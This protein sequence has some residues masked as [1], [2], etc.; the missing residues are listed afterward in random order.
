MR[1]SPNA[2]A[3]KSGLL[4]AAAALLAPTA[5]TAH[6]DLPAWMQQ[7]VSAS[8]IESALYRMMDLPGL[9]TLYPRPPAE[10]RA[11][12][13]TLVQ[14][15]PTNPELY[16]LRARADEQALD[17]TAA[18]QDWKSYVAHAKD[19]PA[20]QLELADYY[21]RRLQPQQEIVTLTALAAA[22]SAPGETFVSASRQRS[23][24]AYS[25]ILKI[26]ADQA[27]PPEASTAAYTAWIARYPGEPS[28][29][30]AYV[31]T[32]IHQQ[33]FD[34]AT[35]VIND[36]KRA[37]PEDQVFPLKAAALIAYRS[38]SSE[39]ALALYAASFQ[40]LWPAELIQSYYGMAAAQH[41]P[42]ELLA[43]ARGAL[44][45]DPDDLAAATRI[46]FYFQQQGNLDAAARAFDEY[47]LSKAS[48]NTAWTCD[49]LY[50][51]ATLLK[52]V[53]LYA[54]SARYDFAL[55]NTPGKLTRSTQAPREAALSGIANIL[56]TAPEQSIDLG[57][58][59][60]SVY[61]DIATLDNGPGYLNG[62][63]SLWLNS[64]SPA[65]E[66]QQEEQ[67]AA[68]YFRRSKAAEVLALLDKDFPNAAT[69]PALHAALVRAYATYGDDPATI[70]A[71]EEFLSAFPNAP[72]RIPVA[73]IVADAYARGKNTT[74]EFAL[75]DHLLADLAH[76]AKGMPLTASTAMPPNPTRTRPDE[77]GDD[78]PASPVLKPTLDQ[79][80]DLTITPATI[81]TPPVD[82]NYSQLLERYLGRLTTTGKLP[83]ALAVLRRE[84]DRNP[85]DPLL[86]VRLADFLQQNNFAAQQEE[87]YRRAIARFNDTTFYD[88]LARF[89]LRK[90]RQQDFTT[91]TRQVVDTFRGTDLE[92]YFSNVNRSWPQV[93]LQLNLYAH[94]RFPHELKF[95]R[96]LLVAY[97]TKGTAD[98]AAWEL[99]LRQHW[100]EADDL[101]NQFFDYLSRTNKLDTELASLQQLVPAESQQQQNPA[102]TRELAEGN[103]WQ[104]H[105]EQSAPLLGSLAHDYPADTAIGDE[106]ASVYRS[107]AYFDPAQAAHAIII[108]QNLSTADPANLDRLTRIGD[109]LAN[110][111]STALSVSVQ[112][113]LAAAA[114][115][116]RR[117]PQ[118][119]PGQPDGY[120][121]A[122]TVFWDYFQF[123]A[124]LSQIDAARKQFHAP[125]LYAYEAG[126]ID[127]NKSAPVQAVAEY[128]TA[129]ITENPTGPARARLLTLAIRPAYAQLVDEATAKAV[130]AHP[131]L[132]TLTLRADVLAA[133]KQPSLV[134]PL[135]DL[136][137]THSST[138][139]QAANLATFA[140]L[141]QL[142]PSYRVA[143]E[144]EITLSADPVQR[145]ELQYTLARSYEQDSQHKDLAA[146]QNII[147]SVYKDDPK[148]LGVVRTT[149]D[150]YWTN[151][152]PQQAIAILVEA[153][154]S[155]NPELA[156]AF[157]LE[158]ATKSNQSSEYAQARTLLAP[159]LA[160]DPY[161]ARYLA[162]I[163]DSYALASD[164]TALR[165]FYTTTL[166]TLKTANLSAGDRRDKTASL[167]QGLIEALTRL[168]DYPGAVDQHIALIS[169]FPEDPG[170]AQ[171][172]ALYALRYNRQQQLVDFLNKT[173]ADSPRDSRFAIT[174]AHVDT[175]FEDYP[176]ALAAYNK[177]IAIR[178]DRPDVYIARADLEEH[179]QHFDEACADYD[180]L[181]VL[182]YKDP[183]WMLKAAEA[184]ARQGKTGLAVRALEAAWIDGR[185]I[186]PQNSFQVA[187]QL[188][189]WNLLT[190][191]RTF[192]EEGI[193]LASEKAPDDL[194]AVPEDREAAATYARILT[195]QRRPADALAVL[196]K[197]LAA[198]NVSPSSPGLIV[199][200]VEKQGIASVTDEQ[201]RR[202]RIEQRRTRAQQSY[203]N[204]VRAMSATVAEF[205]T[206]EEKL[207]Y[208]QLLDTQ[209]TGKSDAE[210][211]SVWIPAAEAAGL[212]DREAEWRRSLLLSRSHMAESQLSPFDTL[213]KQRMDYAVLARTLEDYAAS[214]PANHSAPILTMAADAWA[215]DA[216]HDAE[217]RILRTLNL[218]ADQDAALRE[219]YFRLL[220]AVDQRSLLAQA[221]SSNE[222]Y[223]DAAANYIFSHASQPLA[224]AALDARA[225]ARQP[226]W[227]A[228]NTALAGLF[229]GD[230]SPRTEAA[231]H[232]A[233]ADATIG[234]RL[235]H[236]ADR[237]RQLVGS[238]WFY[239]AT[240]YGVFRTLAPA[241]P[242]E[243]P[244]DYLPASLEA[245]PTAAASYINLAE[246][247]ANSGNPAAAVREYHY[248]LEITPRTAAI[249][250]AIAATLWPLDKPATD[251]PGALDQWQAA[252]RLLRALVNTRVV[253]ES[254]WIDFASIATDLHARDLGSQLRPE[255]DAL[256]RAYIA[257]NGNY[258]TAEL[259][260][261]ALNSQ[262]S[263]GTAATD[264]IFSLAD[265][266]RS[267]SSILDQLDEAN[268]FPRNQRG[269]LYRRQLELAE[270]AAAQ[271][272]YAPTDGSDIDNIELN[273]I[274]IKLLNYLLQQE[275]SASDS[276][277]QSLFN[278]IPASQRQQDDLQAIRIQLAARQNQVSRLLALFLAD[279]ANA[280]SLQII[281]NAANNLRRAGDKASNRLLLEYVFQ[282]KFEQHQ[283]TPPDFLALAQARLDA[284][285]AADTTSALDLLHRLIMLPGTATSGAPS[286]LYANLDA[287]ATLL[288]DAN[289]TAEAIPFLTTLATSTPWNADY[290]LRLAQAQRNVQP[291]SAEANGTLIDIAGASTTT[292][293]TRVE[294]AKFL[295]SKPGTKPFDSAE[296]NLLASGTSITPQQASQPYFLAARVA[297]AASAS[298]S[299]KPAL[300][301]E[302]IA[303]APGDSL[304]LD[305]FRAE[306][307]LRH[308][309]RALSAIQPLLNSPGGY[310]QFRNPDSVPDLNQAVPTTQSDDLPVGLANLPILLRAPE[311][312]V[313]FSLAVASVYEQTGYPAT[314]LNYL[315]TAATLNQ[316]LSCR[317]G[318]AKHIA[319]LEERL[320][321]EAENANRRPV[322]Q[323]GLN[324]AVVVRPRIASELVAAKQVQP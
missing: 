62:I 124:A 120:L 321:I 75:Y 196:Q 15:S 104:S 86:Y 268:W 52:N 322:I 304:R 55:Y 301:R 129:S 294:A 229:F 72:Q 267:P 30:T 74:A 26:A 227:G 302:A 200:Q 61:R 69:R 257:K 36:Y 309:D 96:N 274:R 29:R 102:A 197:T 194:L 183:Q 218:Q 271:R 262:A 255:M 27:L 142:I 115:Y 91:L 283:L 239:Y 123:D 201:W 113:Q 59:N 181:Y 250:R 310:S 221:S 175:I 19:I 158:A 125:A 83:Q 177:A 35:A 134:A 280:P 31:N 82:L 128:V 299:A 173:V 163:A 254:F 287:A 63:L 193:K 199:E 99:L 13:S 161:N 261:S 265:A 311:E 144:R 240:R 300:L 290:R 45:K 14:K 25:R 84:L 169:A 38:G 79:A 233:L 32:L 88:K 149:A 40:P 172:A 282:Q 78:T 278:S 157:T 155:A 98:S 180:H 11:E 216:N 108:E 293:A 168:K 242:S 228:A 77:M 3:R 179:L 198:A 174:L 307:D 241:S 220:L 22:P 10:S 81:P 2:I 270:A 320:R 162:T 6:A 68:P 212:K 238:D 223:A 204:A 298:A 184:R 65:S 43:D 225:H 5:L 105:F 87:V 316:D 319:D 211:A 111:Q 159:L 189:K 76:N 34:A 276:E 281:S 312:K 244:E 313:T 41:R 18:E 166:A 279:P 24:Q 190:E 317:S 252:L 314:A 215:D 205:Y 232:T 303:M 140:Q 230:K 214:R 70:K 202:N 93:Y 107:L 103:L 16:A 305:L 114:P 160:H 272:P 284:N 21:D 297:A 187:A 116:W 44:L 323:P 206:P 192:A 256:L 145:I 263:P 1:S 138:T 236:P 4:L 39:K 253:P 73:M 23:W 54:E 92:Q 153:S 90:K 291:G 318:I 97:R 226:V 203:E 243:D 80:L 100:F 141:H 112:A 57:S 51:L 231:F 224:Y 245:S 133:R 258:R 165:D 119:H 248:A 324:Q 295:K 109:T 127:E 143:L 89:Y 170:I 58:G 118:I 213:E 147:E 94:Q 71:G 286:D 209:R 130:P 67:R 217:L 110:S 277:A 17:F 222:N 264:W 237:A 315:R 210:V 292:Y 28:V 266:S 151:Q 42:R 176:G 249:H 37:F 132:A 178:K 50:T 152:H 259:L 269:R 308:N 246:T 46:F 186:S 288:I 66:L 117:L 139:D 137:I 296:L 289:R 131:T 219:R 188:E 47:R 85:D 251:K 101:R 195:R 154:H 7:I 247:Y 167:R 150:F 146:A 33:R 8:T 95:T 136:A 171:G 191:A 207:T 148:I 60:L 20:A 12:L 208:A 273:P 185:P 285:T 234:D 260:Q 164:N 235:T 126:A 64:T 156:R 182:T 48:R 9:H 53:G 121:Q 122:A 275:N 106:A 306:F 56:L 49:E 135:V